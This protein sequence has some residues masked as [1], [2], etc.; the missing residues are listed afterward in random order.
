MCGCGTVFGMSLDG[1][2]FRTADVEDWPSIWPIFHIVVA[3]G[4]T[5]PYPP[6]T[7]EDEAKQLWMQPGTRRRIT[8]MAE[9]D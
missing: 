3:S 4:D 5:Y 1:L 7:S 2:S 6:D 8:Y 9:M